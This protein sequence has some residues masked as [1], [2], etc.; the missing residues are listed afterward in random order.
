MEWETRR[1]ESSLPAR[2][3][4][5]HR[6]TTKMHDSK[7]Q[8]EAAGDFVDRKFIGE[9]EKIFLARK[10]IFSQKIDYKKSQKRRKKRTKQFRRNIKMITA[11]LLKFYVGLQEGG[12]KWVG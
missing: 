9:E 4:S 1:R 7:I 10:N 5:Y 12:S 8:A 11:F 3:Q 2:R 6:H